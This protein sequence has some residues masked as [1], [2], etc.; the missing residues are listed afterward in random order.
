M[1]VVRE[2]VTKLKALHPPQPFCVMQPGEWRSAARFTR[3]MPRGATAIEIGHSGK[4]SRMNMNRRNVM[5]TLIGAAAVPFGDVPVRHSTTASTS[6]PILIEAFRKSLNAGR[7]EDFYKQWCVP[8]LRVRTWNRTVDADRDGPDGIDSCL[9]DLNKNLGAITL[10]VE[11]GQFLVTP[12]RNRIRYFPRF[13]DKNR[14]HIDLEIS[15]FVDDR[16]SNGFK[17]KEILVGEPGASELGAATTVNI[18]GDGT[19]DVSAEVQAVYDNL[20]RRGGGIL[21]FPPGFFRLSL[22]LNSRNVQLRGAGRLATQLLAPAPGAVILRATYRSG[23]WDAVSISDLGIAGGDHDR[24]VGFRAGQDKDV[25]GDEFAGRT[26]FE[27]VRFADLDICIDRPRGQLGLVI[28]KCQFEDAR[29]HLAAQSREQPGFAMMHAGNIVV[30]ASHF[31]RAREAVFRMDSPVTGSGQIT[32]LDCIMESNPG[33]IF[34]IRNLNAVDSVPAMLVS[35]CW[36]EQ[37]G[38]APTVVID[39]K[40]EK[41]VYARLTNCSLIRF[42]D[43]PVGPLT[44]RNSVVRTLD[45]SLDQLKAVE[46]DNTSLIEHTRA[47]MFSGPTPPGQVASVEATYLNAPGRGVSFILPHRH[48]LSQGYGKAVKISIQADSGIAFSGTATTASTPVRQAVLPGRSIAQQLDL[49]PGMQIF[50]TPVG[51]KAGSWIAWLYIYCHVRGTAPTLSLTGSHGL[52]LET[53]LAAPEWSTLGG[54]TFVAEDA[55]SI[56][57]WHR[58]AGGPA[59][60]LI[61]GMNLLSFSSRQAARDFI[62]GGLFAS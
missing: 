42:E 35:R 23:T 6:V 21:Q 24:A 22:V 18:V 13:L 27:N 44:L 36:N 7:S 52:T 15:F 10:P 50:P 59:T 58:C 28:D 25:P 62:N 17:V 43:T 29:L 2:L 56:S 3:E 1:V 53:P 8:G 49:Q 55:P 46:Q 30:R 31:Q 38:T 5:S 37:N 39:G 9:N 20:V 54:M 26:R 32:F 41:P 34:D 16:S 48:G 57:F 45:C 33:I 19:R 51:L 14:R 60:I 61:G 40:A 47:R 11:A 12:D 4:G